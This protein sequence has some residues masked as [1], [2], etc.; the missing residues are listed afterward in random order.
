MI[1]YAFE[2]A[3]KT[4]L[5]PKLQPIPAVNQPARIFYVPE[6]RASVEAVSPEDA[7]KKA[8]KGKK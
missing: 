2:M 4:K 3:K 6:Y 7:V 1:P 5:T 8:K